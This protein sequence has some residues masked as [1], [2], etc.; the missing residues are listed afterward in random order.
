AR[1]TASVR[2]LPGNSA[3]GAIQVLFAHLA[4]LFLPL[5]LALLLT[6]LPFLLLRVIAC[7]GAYVLRLRD[8]RR[9]QRDQQRHTPARYTARIVVH[10]LHVRYLTR[11]C[12][13]SRSGILMFRHE[14]HLLSSPRWPRLFTNYCCVTFWSSS[15][16]SKLATRSWFL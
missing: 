12:I 14:T 4:A 6:Q 9:R 13:R 7:W 8:Q 11:P 1:Q 3:P 10:K 5:L 16:K 15:S 2:S